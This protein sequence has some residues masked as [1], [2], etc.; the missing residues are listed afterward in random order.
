MYD[1][2][3]NVGDFLSPHWLSEAF[4]GKLRALTKEWRER[5]EHGKPSPLRGLTGITARFLR[6]KADLPRPHEEDY[7]RAVTTLHTLLLDA[8]GFEAEPTEVATEQSETPVVVPVLARHQAP[9]G[10][11][12]HV[13]QAEPVGD[14]DDLFGEDGRLLAPVRV[15]AG[16]ERTDEVRSVTKA[17]QQLFLTEHAPRFVLVVAGGWLILSDV[18][19]WAEGRYL[20]F[21]VDTALSRKD[22]KPAGELAWLAGLTSADVLLPSEEGTSRLTEFTDDSI[23]HAVAVNEGLREGLRASV[24]LIANEVIARRRARGEPVEDIPELPRELTTQSLRFLYRIL[25]LLYAEAR[26]ELGILPVGAP[27]YGAGYGLDRLRELIQRPLTGPSRDGHHLHDS[28]RLLF[29][30]VNRGHGAGRSSDDGLVFTPLRA[31]LF[32]RRHAYHIDD[33][34]LSNAVLQQVLALLLL[35]KPSKSKGA[36]RGYVSYAQLGINQLGAVYEGL[37]AYSGFIA[38][39]EL[40][41]LAKDGDPAKGTWLVPREKL[42]DYDERHVVHREDPL[43]GEKSFVLHRPGTFV[44]RLSGRDRQRSAS[45]YTPEVLT[46]CVVRHSLA[47]LITDDTRATEI[48]DYRICEPAMGSGAFLNEAI[49]QLAAEYLRRRQAELDETIDPEQYRDELQKV[50][51]YLALHRCY[52]VDLNDT[53]RELAEV[54]LWLNV[55]HPGL[56]AP[57]FGLHLRRGNSLIGARR[58]TY[59]LAALGRTKKSWLTTPPT[60][61]PLSEGAVPD[62]EIHHF[63][64]PAAGWGAVKDAKQAKE[65]APEKVAQLKAWTKAVTR[66]PGKEETQRLRGL[67]RRVERLWELSL[68]RLEISEREVSRHINVWGAATSSDAPAVPR[69]QV[70]SALHDPDGPYQRLRLAMDAWCA[71]F[72]WPITTDIEPPDLTQWITG[73]EGLLG[74]SGKAGP[75]SQIEFTETVEGFDELADLDDLEKSYY[76][77]RDVTTLLLDYRWLGVTREITKEEGFLHWELDFAQVFSRDGFDLQLGN[78][79]WVRPKWF[80]DETLAESEPFFVLQD[81]IPDATFRKRRAE[82]LA[83]GPAEHRY[84][85][86]L[87]SWA[88][89]NEHLGSPVEHPVLCGVQTNLYTSFMDRTWRSM[90]D[91]GIVGLLHPETHFTAPKAG[92]LRSA[93]Y[94][95]LRRYANFVEANRWFDGVDSP[96]QTFGL[97]CYGKPQ[98]ISF[99]M[100]TNLR[101]VET[102]DSSLVHDGAGEVP[103]THYAAGGLDTRP[104]RSRVVRVTE[105]SLAQWVFLFDE[106]GTPANHARLVRPVTREQLEALSVMAEQATRMADITYK[107]TR[108]W[109]EDRIKKEG[110]GVWRT[111]HPPSWGEAILQGP[112]F[113][114]AT[115]FAKEPNENCRSKAD[116]SDW[117]LEELPAHVIPRTNY[118]RATDRDRYDAGLT[119][120]RGRP[121]TDYYRLAWRKMTQPGSERSLISSIV[122]PGPAHIDSVLSLSTGSTRDTALLAG[123]WASIPFDYLVKTSGT[124]NIHPAI[125]DR[126]PAPISH[127]A[128]RFLLQRTLRLNCLTR[129]YAPLWEEL[130]GPELADDS[131]TRPFSDWPPLGVGKRE[132][133]RETPLRSEFERRAALVE[134]DALA[135]VMLGLTADQLCLM[136]RGQFAVLRKYE[137]NMWFDNLGQKI[138]KEHHAHGVKQQSEDFKLLQ[139]YLNEEDCGDLLDRYEEPIT[140][141]DREA[142]MRA[143]YADFVERLR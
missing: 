77:M 75:S 9:A 103:G 14:I 49:N 124:A 91:A 135:A 120:W 114:V 7:S 62:G 40:V 20:A 30:L 32:D 4:P 51:A 94:Q 141:V 136:Y 82:V 143:A 26:P 115:P 78:P 37:M 48:L 18:E 95:H 52:G 39:R 83:H 13:L 45:Y 10:E 116:Y 125:I 123:L 69:E 92:R 110:Y 58:A 17:V 86:E 28:L 8:L 89:L 119:L 131:W 36:Q 31:D 118:Q 21:D 29:G 139:A 73:L 105:E 55:M 5:T 24:E 66:R 1:S 126:F 85:D 16:P 109:D 35:S 11:A 43:T 46:R 71:L 138:A 113:S 6:A 140:P 137:Y 133:H 2:I 122:V 74:V 22:D 33:V 99:D 56:Q 70:E 127:P 79:P 80:D 93:A 132:W 88:G 34:D 101:A 117:D 64:L 81:K 50:K 41:E 65:L 104:H 63:L 129:D 121:Y 107:W 54:S 61:R 106:P 108:G 72:F 23:K 84:L 142:E 44:Y 97:Q 87:S 60:D 102:L 68:R 53:A 112:H 12:L 15:Q 128:A 90:S 59:D 3:R 47:E 38:E 27:E 42:G 57:W 76:G 134:I 98:N 130:Y 100:I 96:S 19:R 67:A 25:F 111:E